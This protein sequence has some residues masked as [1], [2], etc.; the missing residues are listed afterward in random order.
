M[1]VFVIVALLGFL[2]ADFVGSGHELI[3]KILHGEAVWYMLLLALGIRAVLLLFANNTGVSGGMFVPMLAFGAIIAALISE[4]VFAINLI[5]ES[6]ASILIAIGMASFLAAASRTPITALAF[7]LEV[8]CGINN[9]LPVGMGIVFAYLIIEIAKIPAFNDTVIEAM[10]ET[11]VDGKT[12]IIVTTKLTIQAGAFAIGQEV[13]DILWPPTCTVLSIQKG[14]QSEHTH[15]LSEGDVLELRYQ[16]F[17]P[18]ATL[19]T[20][21]QIL[22]YQLKE[23]KLRS[24]I[25]KK[26][27]EIPAD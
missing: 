9:I 14:K 17:N 12:P 25:R 15:A 8:L 21:Y 16:T 11:E 4:I 5:D 26:N 13:R 22:G 18:D 2:S 10:T 3:E 24:K 7:A 20:L 23:P 6:Y 1:L 19:E 27:H